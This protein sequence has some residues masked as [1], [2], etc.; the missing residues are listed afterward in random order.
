MIVKTEIDSF[1]WSEGDSNYFDVK[2]KVFKK[3]DNDVI[4]LV[5]NLTIGATDF[6]YLK[7]L[8]NQLVDGAQNF[9]GEGLSLVQVP[10]M[11]MYMVEQVK[12][13]DKVVGV[14]DPGNREISET[15]LRYSVDKLDLSIAQ[16]RFFAPEDVDQTFNQI[17]YVK[18]KLNLFINLMWWVLY[19]IK[20]MLISPIVT[21]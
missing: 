19:L 11:S 5:Q 20:F 4:Q 9:R 16:V 14:V 1:F 15:L 10:T 3:D 7:K 18:I 12:L 13:A 2:L 21:L 8:Q 6:N 17:V